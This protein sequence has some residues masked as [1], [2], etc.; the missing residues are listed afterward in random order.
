MATPPF[1]VNA[2]SLVSPGDILDLLPHSRIPRPLRVARKFSG[3][4]P[5]GSRIQGEVREV[6]EVGKHEPK[7]QFNWDPPGEEILC[8]ARMARAVFL[9]WAAKWRMTKGVETYTE[10]IG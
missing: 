4:L 10:K 2:G 5:K 9:T 6:F 7:P 8:N 1:Y 3:S